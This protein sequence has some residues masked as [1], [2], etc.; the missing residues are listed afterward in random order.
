VNAGGGTLKILAKLPALA[1]LA[2]LS[3]PAHAEVPAWVQLV[4][5]NRLS[6]RAIIENG[7]CPSFVAD[8]KPLKVEVRSDVRER[9]RMMTR[10][11]DDGSMTV[12]AVFSI[13]VQCGH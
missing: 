5:H 12:G 9:V 4:D 2:M 10:C 13:A 3:T 1:V 7:D 6:A 11:S 8:G